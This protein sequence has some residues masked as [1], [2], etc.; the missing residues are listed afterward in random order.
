M[1][2]EA[3]IPES[4]KL[5]IFEPNRC[6]GPHRDAMMFDEFACEHCGR[7][8]RKVMVFFGDSNA[9]LGRDQWGHGQCWFHRRDGRWLCEACIAIQRAE[10]DG[11]RPPHRA[12]TQ[13]NL[14]AAVQAGIEKFLRRKQQKES[15][16]QKISHEQ[17]AIS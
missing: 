13:R 11:L 3:K 1:S 10:A 9:A 4:A 2:D 6:W 17:S 7:Q 8:A 5:G 14:Y 16:W 12:D 15:A